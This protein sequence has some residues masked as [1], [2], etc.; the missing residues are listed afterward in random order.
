MASQELESL[1]ASAPSTLDLTDA[2][3]IHQVIAAAEVIISLHD[4]QAALSHLENDLADDKD[5]VPFGA[6][7]HQTCQ[8]QVNHRR[9][10][11]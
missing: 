1:I 9:S 7:G 10:T 2:D 3:H 5:N 8:I 4:N 11:G 6:P